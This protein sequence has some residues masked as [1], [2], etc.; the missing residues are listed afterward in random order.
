MLLDACCVRACQG[1]S[2]S[3]ASVRHGYARYPIQKDVALS[4]C[5]FP[6]T[7]F[8]MSQGG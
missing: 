7:E 4:L 1:P 3:R 2:F 6:P 8:E 5:H